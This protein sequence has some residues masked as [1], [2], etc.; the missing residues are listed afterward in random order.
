MHSLVLK[1]IAVLKICPSFRKNYFQNLLALKQ[2]FPDHTVLV[3]DW[4]PNKHFSKLPKDYLDKSYKKV[5]W[6]RKKGHEKRAAIVNRT[7]GKSDQRKNLAQKTQ[8]F[9]KSETI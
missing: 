7:I 8:R 5:C 1:T 9:L 4:H 3:F 6:Q 2:Y